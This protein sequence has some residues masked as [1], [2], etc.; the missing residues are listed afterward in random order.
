MKST[1]FEL[2]PNSPVHL[3]TTFQEPFGV[4]DKNYDNVTLLHSKF[5]QTIHPQAEFHL[6]LGHGNHGN[7]RIIRTCQTNSTEV[8]FQ[9]KASL[10]PCVVVFCADLDWFIREPP[11]SRLN[12]TSSGRTGLMDL[13][14]TQ[15]LDPL[16]DTNSRLISQ[17]L[18]SRMVVNFSCLSH[19]FGMDMDV[20]SLC[21][22]TVLPLTSRPI[23]YVLPLLRF[24]SYAS[25]FIRG[26]TF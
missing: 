21:L 6:D 13:G 2:A 15:P 10:V 3:C 17:T 26:R 8:G 14:T 20:R 16:E 19:G 12:T 5:E 9:L 25:L 18:W 11:R 24:R 4:S 22:N 7:R 1:S 23:S